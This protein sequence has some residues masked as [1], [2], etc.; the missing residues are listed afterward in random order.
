MKISNPLSFFTG[1]IIF[2]LI[3]LLVFINIPLQ[4][5]SWDIMGY[6]VYWTQ[7]LVHH[8]IHIYNLD[9]YKSIEE[10]YQNTN[11]LYQFV[12]T[13]SGS[14]I[15]KYPYGWALLNAPFILLGHLYAVLFGYT[16]DGF[17]MPY[18]ISALLSSL[19]Y[20]G[21]GIYWFRKVLLHFFTDKWTVFILIAV[22]LGTNYLHINYLAVGMT[23]V[24]L[25]TLYAALLLQT[26][27][28]HQTYRLKNALL[29]G[30]IIGLMVATRPT[31]I[32][33]A[34]IP[35]FWG[36]TS[37]SGLF[38][39]IKTAFTKHF[40]LYFLAVAMAV[41][42]IFPQLLYWKVT[43]GTWLFYSYNNAGEGLDLSSPHTYKFLFSF[44]KG[45]W[46]YT[47]IMFFATLGFYH[48]YKNN[49]DIFW[50][51]FIYFILNIYL[52]SSWT[53]WWYADSFSQR[54][55]EQSYPVMALALGYY[56]I[57]QLKWRN[58][59]LLLFSILISFN[60][61]QTY[62][63]YQGILPSDRITKDYYLSVFGQ[64]SLPTQE[65][66]KL[67]S[68]E[69]NQTVFKNEN[70]YTMIHTIK[71]EEEMPL[72]MTQDGNMFSKNIKRAYK[73]LTSKDHLWIR[74]YSSVIPQGNLENTDFHFTMAMSHKGNS[75][76]WRGKR[77]DNENYSSPKKNM[78]VF[79]YLT[80]EIRLS[81]DTLSVGLWLQ[82]GDSVLLQSFYIE[83]W[84]PKND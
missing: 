78:F 50:S 19:F 63:F 7:L 39:R 10:T 82:R 49:K 81:S 33:A 55:I 46:V 44:R 83:V 35:L 13:E 71:S 37:F 80:P 11:T 74:G 70:D 18:Q 1:L 2:C 21:L 47:P 25:F 28:F 43:T 24:Y 48:I 36:V 65:Q 60:L 69:R 51:L 8:D 4:T 23:H 59:L 40:K 72:M 54:A 57:A 30:L 73:D 5:L 52:V 79:D 77:L 62:Q 41:L 53:T 6:H 17:S 56:L 68:I 32:V 27:S 29:I 42:L 84:E 12:G 26:I 31:E 76:T 38:N 58:P 61:F 75:Y 22:L 45:W 9:F 14:S 64:L 20:T 15:T 16:I 3:L 67:L 34:F 66:L